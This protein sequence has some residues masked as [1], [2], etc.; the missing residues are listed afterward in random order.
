MPEQVPPIPSAEDYHAVIVIGFTFF[1][2]LV[3]G[4]GM[5]ILFWAVIDQLLLK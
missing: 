1:C 2:G 5:G 4:I 3:M